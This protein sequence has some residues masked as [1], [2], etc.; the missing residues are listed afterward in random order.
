MMWQNAPKTTTQLIVDSHQLIVT[1]GA[2]YQFCPGLYLGTWFSLV[3]NVEQL[4]QSGGPPCLMLN[5]VESFF[6]NI[7]PVLCLVLYSLYF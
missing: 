6:F 2:F 1:L 3:R 4:V 5:Q 7:Y